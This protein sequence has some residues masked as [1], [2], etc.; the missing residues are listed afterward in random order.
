MRVEAMSQEHVIVIL[1][2]VVIVLLVVVAVLW[3]RR[4]QSATTPEEALRARLHEDMTGWVLE[5]RRLF[6][7]WQERIEGLN[8]LKSRLGSMAEEANR[9]RIEV[10]HVEEMRAQIV[11]LT[12][13]NE[14]CA[15]ERAD[16]HELLGRIASLAQ[17]AVG[18]RPSR[19]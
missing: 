15:K 3:S 6:T 11:R 10:S 12:D 5:G 8:E 4:G 17:E 13:E 18:V 7:T 1:G 16:L 2:V 9:L 14:R 19:P